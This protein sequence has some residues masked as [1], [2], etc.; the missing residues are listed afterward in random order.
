MPVRSETMLPT[1]PLLARLMADH[2]AKALRYCGVSVVNVLTGAS[3][4]AFC[5]GVLHWSGVASNLMAWSV[6]TV[7]AYLLS[8]AW[9]WQQ[10]GSH[11]LSGE[12]VPFWVMAFVGLLLSTFVVN[13]V[14]QRTD[15]TTLVLVALLGTYGVVWVVKYVILDK[16]MWRRPTVVDPVEIG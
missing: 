15:R 10:S 11:R 8:R 9:V 1:E 5:H 7:P 14:D 6:S 2:G 4:L 13:L 12:V 16:V 3:T